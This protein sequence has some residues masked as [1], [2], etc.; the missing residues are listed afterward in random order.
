MHQHKID[1]DKD[2][3]C[4]H[5]GDTCKD[6]SIALENNLFCCLGC[7]TVF[8]I[9]SGSGLE[10]YYDIEKVPGIKLER[11]KSKEHFA[12]LDEPSIAKKFLLFED[13]EISRISFKLPQ[14]H[15]SSCIWLLENLSRLDAGV[16]ISSVNFSNKTAD[17]TFSNEHITLRQLVELLSSIGYEPDLSLDDNKKR[18]TNKKLIYKIG[19]AGF[20]FG[21]I[22][23][24]A[25]PE[26]LGIDASF[27]V[28]QEIFAYASL[29]LAIPVVFYSGWDY[30]ES[31]WKSLSQKFINI[32]VPIA[33][34]II[35]LLIRSSY[36]IISQTGAGY[37]DSLSGLIFFLLIGKWFQ[38]KTYAALSFERDYK[39]YFPIAA[40]KVLKSKVIPTRI[41]D[42]E[43]GDRVELRNNELIPAD[44]VLIDGDAL[45]DY[46]FVTG[47]SDGKVRSSGAPL[48]A[49]GRQIGTKILIELTKKVNNS[50]LTELWGH[51]AFQKDKKENDLEQISNKVSKYFTLVILAITLVTAFYWY[52]NDVSVLWNSVTAVLIVACPCALALSVPFTFG[53]AVRIFGRNGLYL[54]NSG[55]IEK[56]AELT[57]IV[58][59]KTGTLTTRQDMD[60]SF[61][62]EGLQTSE[63][64]AINSIVDQSM[65]PLSRA[66]SRLMGDQ[67]SLEV[68]SF[69][70]NMGSGVTGIV[71]DN[72]IKVGSREF[73]SYNNGQDQTI[74]GSRAYVTINDKPRGYFQILQKYRSALKSVVNSLKPKYDLHILSGDNNSQK[75][76]L[77]ET[78]DHDH[79]NFDRSPIEKLRFIEELQSDGKKVMMIGDGLNDAGALKQSDLGLALSDDLHQFSPASDAIL[80]AKKFGSI[81]KLL[82][83][84]KKCIRIVYV[85]FAVSFLY[86]IIGLYFAT[87]GQLSPVIAAILMPISSIS[88]VVLATILT[89]S[90]AKRSL[91]T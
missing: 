50:Y 81:P 69:K 47:E 27:K 31:A 38:Q 89:K 77:A 70:E 52:L 33:I 71:D 49:G 80:D 61:H 28:F 75:Q 22:M 83:Y 45:I 65:H 76:F 57:T 34:G 7:K 1:I 23:L 12:Y 19:V 4:H 46:S 60:V 8:E 51:R 79:L 54:K 62:G 53:N 55:V 37:F 11:I 84:S 26:Y 56:M 20:C 72:E 44:S 10:K 29:L 9:L 41:E 88:I 86:N 63:K 82:G 36:E 59:D 30:L 35:T 14:I 67:I 21:N 2:L 73:T 58:F 16:L 78:F 32:D 25:F 3:K 43:I 17:I 48:F 39:S 85:S 68:S 13:K 91:E 24:M 87:T 42:L 18:S 5:C 15:C 74:S 66:I 6:N 90:L 40:N 64:E